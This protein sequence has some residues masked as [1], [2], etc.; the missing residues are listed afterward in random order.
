MNAK[1]RYKIT[2]LIQ[3][4]AKTIRNAV[5]TPFLTFLILDYNPAITIYI[6]IRLQKIPFSA[7]Q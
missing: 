6:T 4:S 2:N 1:Q 5:L 3:T 7:F